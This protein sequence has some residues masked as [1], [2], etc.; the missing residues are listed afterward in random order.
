MIYIIIGAGGFGLYTALNLRKLDKNSI[1]KII[2]KDKKKS[3]TVKGGNGITSITPKPKNLFNFISIRRS[4]KYKTPLYINNINNISWYFFYIINNLFNDNRKKIFELTG[5]SEEYHEYN[6]WDNIYKLCE[7]NNIEIIEDEIK[8]YD[9]KIIYGN[10]NYNYDK[11][12][13]ATGSDFSLLKDN[14]CNKEYINYINLFS[15]VAVIVKVKNVPNKFYFANDVFI[16]PYKDDTVKITCLLQLGNV[17]D[18]NKEKIKEYIKNNLEVKKL[19]FIDIIDYWEGSRA[20]TYD[21]IPFYT[22]LINKNNDNI[23]WISGG[24]FLGSHTCELFGE[25]LAEYIIYNKTDEYFTL[26]RLIKI[27]KTYTVYFIIIILIII[28]IIYAY[29]N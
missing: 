19:G 12:I 16:T 4:C 5:E 2:D 15:G 10:N 28:L 27:K 24:S 8:N 6:Y 9:D 3:A 21:T 22:K 25:K 14:E 1:I 17:S 23:Y 11:L 13:L 20:V 7:E 18:I 26:K 29:K